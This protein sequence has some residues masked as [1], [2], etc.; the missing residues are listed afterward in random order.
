[1]ASDGVVHL[2]VVAVVDDVFV[3]GV[4]LKDGSFP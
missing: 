2:A 4:P 1:M 3:D